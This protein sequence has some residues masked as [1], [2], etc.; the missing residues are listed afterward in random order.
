[1]FIGFSNCKSW[2]KQN[3]NQKYGNISVEKLVTTCNCFKIMPLALFDF[4]WYN[5]RK[6]TPGGKHR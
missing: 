4:F 2:E 5:I 3:K 1:M 6:L